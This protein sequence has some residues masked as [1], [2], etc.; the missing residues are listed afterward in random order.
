MLNLGGSFDEEQDHGL[1]ESPQRLLMS[2][3]IMHW[4]NWKAFDGVIKINI[5]NVGQVGKV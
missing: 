2:T 5:T 3:V 4:R 1:E